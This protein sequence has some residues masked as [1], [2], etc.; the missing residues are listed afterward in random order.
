LRIHVSTVTT[1]CKKIRLKN[2]Q[3]IK[4]AMHNDKKG[5][6]TKQMLSHGH[7]KSLSG[8]VVSLTLFFYRNKSTFVRLISP[9]PT[10][11]IPNL[12][13]V[14]LEAVL[15]LAC[16]EMDLS[17]PLLHK[18]S[19][20]AAIALQTARHCIIPNKNTTYLNDLNNDGHSLES[21]VFTVD[22]ASDTAIIAKESS[23][24]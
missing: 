19:C 16:A 18:T 15:V 21:P 17:Q 22:V 10:Q 20:K 2:R 3:K 5:T 11:H 4:K 1:L 7:M 24:Q 14:Q 12:Q 23:Y 8:S 6:S 13:C 9:H